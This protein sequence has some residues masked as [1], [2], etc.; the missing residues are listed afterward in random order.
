[1]KKEVWIV[2]RQK[3]QLG[4][5]LMFFAHVYAWCLHTGREL[6]YPSFSAQA[7]L[8][9][10]IAGQK[11][12]SVGDPSRV[13]WSLEDR[14]K[15]Q[16][17]YVSQMRLLTKLRLAF[18]LGKPSGL[19][20]VG[21]PPSY[22]GYVSNWIDRKKKVYLLGW[23]YLNPVGIQRYR[24]EILAATTPTD[25]LVQDASS[26]AA[27]LDPLR[28]WIGVHVRGTD[29]KQFLGG[30]HAL[31]LETTK[32]AMAEAARRF[33]P[34]EVGFVIFSDEPR[35]REEFAGFET[36]ISGGKAEEDLFRM[37]TLPGLIGPMSTFST[38]AMYR[39]G[40]A[41][42]QIGPDPAEDGLEWAFNGWPVTRDVERWTSAVL[43]AR[44]GSVYLPEPDLSVRAMR[45]P[46]RPHAAV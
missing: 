46:K 8:F 22:E 1:M 9:P 3:G 37:A 18:A 13:D 24:R 40:G 30:K 35:T 26:F 14:L 5:R 45:P 36:V 42:W 34:A 39:S 20:A 12:N 16:K 4:N 29:Y 28:L 15:F 17:R 23:R 7:D 25:A 21:L 43:A 6:Y 32:Q 27:R 38:W 11:F 44:G 10:A 19:A 2:G 31:P 41:A 33:A